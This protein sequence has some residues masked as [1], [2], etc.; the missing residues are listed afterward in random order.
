MRLSGGALRDWAA[1]VSANRWRRLMRMSGGSDENTYDA[2]A[3]DDIG[4]QRRPPPAGP[5]DSAK[6]GDKG[7]QAQRQGNRHQ[8]G[9]QQAGG[10][11]DLMPWTQFP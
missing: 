3:D 6:H 8:R 1:A 7:H 11:R 5:V 4:Q 9:E 2:Q 10:G